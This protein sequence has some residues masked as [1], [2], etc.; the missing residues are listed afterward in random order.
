M[1]SRIS[2]SI[3]NLS[4]VTPKHFSTQ[5][6]NNDSI[7]DHIK[8]KEN[9]SSTSET[10][11]HDGSSDDI[12]MVT[13]FVTPQISPLD[14]LSQTPTETGSYVSDNSETSTGSYDNSGYNDAGGGGGCGASG[15]DGG[16]GGG[17]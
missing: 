3:R 8:K 4:L 14:I 7:P 1:L 11:S 17:D 6:I 10:K 13:P 15:G 2:S 5:I 9:N 12:D 16:G